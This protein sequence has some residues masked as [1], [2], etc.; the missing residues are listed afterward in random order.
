MKGYPSGRGP[1]HPTYCRPGLGVCS[2]WIP[3]SVCYLM[4]TAPV[5]ICRSTCLVPL[6]HSFFIQFHLVNSAAVCCP[7]R[8]VP[9]YLHYTRIRVPEITGTR[10]RVHTIL[11]KRY[12]RASMAK[13]EGSVVIFFTNTA[14]DKNIPV[15]N[16]IYIQCC[17]LFLLLLL[18]AAAAPV[19]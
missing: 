10:R 17:T 12:K 3:C 1:G 11:K 15:C 18:P 4:V 9:G 13:K 5:R 14:E 2:A 7:G 16:N 6:L 8:R 19:V